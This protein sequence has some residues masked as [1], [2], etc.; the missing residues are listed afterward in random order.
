MF[1]YWTSKRHYFIEKYAVGLS[2]CPRPYSESCYIGGLMEQMQILRE[3]IDHIYWPA[4]VS[5]RPALHS[6]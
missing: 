2:E 4:T 6:G 1:P 5:F 3:G